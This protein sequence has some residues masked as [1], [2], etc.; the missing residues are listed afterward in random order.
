MPENFDQQRD[1]NTEIPEG[2]H[3][4][5]PN[6]CQD[7]ELGDNDSE[8]SDYFYEELQRDHRFRVPM[9]K[10]RFGRFQRRERRVEPKDSSEDRIVRALER[11]QDFG[12]RVEVEDFR[13]HFDP[14]EFLDWLHN[15]EHF[16]E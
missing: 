7:E 6:G 14:N 13:G 2:A 1:Q 9:D 3:R 4:G 8:F 16:F 10:D 15:I 5:K 11:S 12:I